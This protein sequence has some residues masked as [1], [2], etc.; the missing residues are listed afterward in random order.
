VGEPSLVK[1]PVVVEGTCDA[2]FERVRAEFARGFG[3]LAGDPERGEI[4]AALAVAIGGRLVVDLWAGHADPA[5]IR[6][7]RRDTLANVY[8]STK[9][10]TALAVHKLVDAGR[11]DLETPVAHYWPEFAAAGKAEL[12]V[13]WLLTHRAGLPALRATFLASAVRDPGLL[14]KALAAET[15]W[16]T[17]GVRHGY[18]A[19]TFGWLLG[20]LVRRVTGDSVGTWVRE[21]LA[22]PLGLDLHI[23]LPAF[24]HRRIADLTPLPAEPASEA[25]ALIEHALRVP[26]SATA[27]AFG[28]PPDMLAPGVANTEAWRVAEIPAANGHATARAL[29]ELYSAVTARSAPLLSPESSARCYGEA[30]RGADEVLRMQTRFSHGFMLSDSAARFGPGA[31]AFGHPGAGGSLGLGDP[32]AEIGFGYVPN[33]MGSHILLDPRPAALVDALYTCL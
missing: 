25:M 20:E 9:G 29:A 14:A 11:V 30:A 15:P 27:R 31:R 6:P 13:G 33:R 16:W 19:F 28:N 10:I 24:E 21:T 3:E 5:K 17:P 22:G 26:D 2:R 18:H 32:D 7:W 1:N 23:G 8:S 12:P 4:G